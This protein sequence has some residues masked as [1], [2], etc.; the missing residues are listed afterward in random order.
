LARLNAAQNMADH[1]QIAELH[2]R[3]LVRLAANSTAL[4]ATSS[5]NQQR[6][7]DAHFRHRRGPPSAPPAA[8]PAG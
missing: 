1:G 5:A 7:A 2:A 4:Y 6:D 8:L 3:R